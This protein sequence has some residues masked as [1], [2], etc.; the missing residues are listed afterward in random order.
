MNNIFLVKSPLQLLNAIEAKHHFGLDDKDCYLLVM[1]DRKSYSQLMKLIV[2]SQQWR[3][4]ILMNRVGL[5]IGNPWSVNEEF[6][7]IDRLRKTLLRSSVFFIR[8]L[9][10][11]VR[12]IDDVQYIFVGDN[13]NPLMRHFVNSLHHEHTVLLDDGTATLDIARQRMQGQT[14]RKPNRLS[15]KI[16]LAAKRV[17]QKL[18]DQQPDSVE[19]FTAYNIEVSNSDRVISNDFSYLRKQAKDLPVT[20]AIYFLGSPLSEV[21]LM[22]E[23]DYL[24][25][26]LMVRAEYADRDFVYVAHRREN[27]HKLDA[28]S[29]YPGAQVRLFEY[30]VEY[31]L[32]ILGPRPTTIASFF[33]SALDNLNIILGD[34]IN[35]TA[36][37]LLEG[38]YAERERVDAVYAH[39]LSNASASFQVKMLKKD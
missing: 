8:R 13:N 26:L 34:S 3:N 33:T 17:L 12:A 11:L 25:Q 37:H 10:R 1:G 28:I 29:Q 18:N 31:Q 36:Y 30:P 39:Y 32:A 24:Q 19:F 22:T 5:M 38:S 7:D 21:G 6:H 20:D 9:N 2:A 4:V 35:I 14:A 27:R 16:R 15:K 23:A